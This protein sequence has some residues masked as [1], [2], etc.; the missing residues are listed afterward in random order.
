MPWRL[1]TAYNI[2][3]DRGNVVGM[4]RQRFLLTGTYQLPFGKG[5]AFSGTGDS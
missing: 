1:P 3:Y 4:P 5:Q 2:K